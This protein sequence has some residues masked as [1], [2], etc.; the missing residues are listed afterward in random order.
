MSNAALVRLSREWAIAELV[1]RDVA[2]WGEGEREAAQRMRGRLSHGRALNS[3]A[4]YDIDN[5]D[6]ELAREAQRVM[7][8]R[9][10][11]ELRKGG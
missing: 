4:H 6:A 3:L 10:R 8:E 11:A 7:T 5:I 9:D 2:R 1:E